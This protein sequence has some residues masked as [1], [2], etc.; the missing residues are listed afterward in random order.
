ML[1]KPQC[2]AS[3]KVV[4]H[5]HGEIAPSDLLIRRINP[6]Q[7]LVTDHNTNRRRVSSKAYQP[8]SEPNGGMSVDHEGLMLADSRD[9]KQF[10]AAPPFLGAVC[11]QATVARSSGLL[12]GYD[13][14][15]GNPYHCEV[16][17][18]DRPNRFPRS[19]VNSH[20]LQPMVHTD[21]GR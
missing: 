4:P 21:T 11:F 19:A 5:D 9:P 3:G 17:G 20:H 7:H 10:V 15:P 6:G 1:S 13:P 14:I 16:W 18:K 8:S 12:V 2:D